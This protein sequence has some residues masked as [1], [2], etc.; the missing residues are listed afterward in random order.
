MGTDNMPTSLDDHSNSNNN[1]LLTRDNKHRRPEGRRRRRRSDGAAADFDQAVNIL[2]H[3]HGYA[4]R[5]LDVIAE[6]SES[7]DDISFNSLGKTRI[8]KA[9]TCACLTSLAAASA[10]DLLNAPPL[11]NE[12]D[13]WGFY[14]EDMPEPSENVPKRE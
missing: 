2:Q 3:F 9:V 10:Q 13:D 8:R 1:V 14:F 6:H 5:S 7:G 12:S 11:A 4:S